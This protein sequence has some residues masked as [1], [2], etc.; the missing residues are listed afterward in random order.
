MRGP[1]ARQHGVPTNVWWLL[2]PKLPHQDAATPKSASFTFPIP[3][4][5]IL[6]AFTSRWMFPF[7]W[8]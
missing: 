6:P 7:L 8:K 5:R 3:S 4:I 2:D 1:G